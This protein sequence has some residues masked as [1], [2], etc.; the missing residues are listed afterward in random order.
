MRCSRSAHPMASFVP[1]D[2]T[3]HCQLSRG[4]YQCHRCRHQASLIA[5]TIFHG[6]HLPLTMWFLA[7]ISHEGIEVLSIDNDG[8]DDH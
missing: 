5:G 2:N 6:T 7:R 4:V 3:T 1:P 8:E